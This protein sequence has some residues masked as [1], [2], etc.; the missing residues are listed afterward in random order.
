MKYRQFNKTVWAQKYQREHFAQTHPNQVAP[1]SFSDFMS[2][3]V[4]S[5]KCFLDCCPKKLNCSDCRNFKQSCSKT[6]R[7]KNWIAVHFKCT[8]IRFIIKNHAGPEYPINYYLE[9]EV[10]VK[11]RL[12]RCAFHMMEMGHTREL[13]WILDAARLRLTYYTSMPIFLHDTRL[14]KNQKR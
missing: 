12:D 14:S 7:L 5:Q 13:A 6:I 1:I 10:Y 8:R 11:H 2:L 3:A 9:H 4:I